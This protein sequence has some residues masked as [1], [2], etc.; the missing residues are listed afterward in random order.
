MSSTRKPFSLIIG[1]LLMILLGLARGIGG[2]IL[3]IQGKTTLPNMNT[4]ETVLIFLSFG[5]ILIGIFEIISAVGIYYLKRKYWFL[6]I[7]VTILFVIDGAIN[8]YLLFGKPGDQGTVINLIAAI[9]IITFLLLGKKSL[10][11][12]K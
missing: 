1:A 6:G 11:K 3:L 8:G 12:T 10:D 2:I 7:V 9:I 4:N 5:L